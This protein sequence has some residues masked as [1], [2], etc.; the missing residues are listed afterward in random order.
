MKVKLALP[1]GQLQAGT[2]GLLERAALEFD[3]YHEGSGSYRPNCAERPGLF[4]KVLHEKDIA[5]QVAIGNYDLGICRLDWVEE[6]LTKYHG[7]AVTRI[8]EF[9]Y[10]MRGVYA[11]TACEAGCG[12][13]EALRQRSG[14]LRIV[15]EYPN[16]AESF[17]LERRLKHFQI[18]PVWGATGA[19]LPEHAEL[20][21]VAA[22]SPERLLEQGLSPVATLLESSACLVANRNSLARKDLRRVL[23]ALCSV[24]PQGLGLEDVNGNGVEPAANAR[25]YGQGA[26]SLALPDGHQQRHMLQFL[27]KAGIGIDGYE[28]DSTISRPRIALDGIA[29]KVIRPQDMPQQ[30]ANGNFDMA[31]T[32]RDWLRDH[33]LRF[34]SSPVEE[35]LE[36]GFGRVRIVAVVNGDMPVSRTGDLRRSER[37]AALRVAS[38]YVNIADRY[39]LEN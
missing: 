38:E 2:A 36:L 22:R 26:V 33:R 4:V 25:D 14:S 8:R 24:D 32:G 5:I 29:V 12:S 1:K 37:E 18:F 3:Q 13:L 23:E 27:K 17:A 34:P 19:Y 28:L 39:A 16:L 15:T 20:A 35:M 7:D 30:V 10:G 11:A 21:V 31:V 9:G 6:L